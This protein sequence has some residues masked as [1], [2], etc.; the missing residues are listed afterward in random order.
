MRCLSA[1]SRFCTGAVIIGAA[2]PA[3]S[4][5]CAWL[6]ASRP[7]AAVL[8][9]AR[10]AIAP[11]GSGRCGP[12]RSLITGP[13][14]VS[15]TFRIWSGSP[16][17][18]MRSSRTVKG[19]GPSGVWY[20]SSGCRRLDEHVLHVGAGGG[21]GPGDVA[22][23][24]EHQEWH[25][26]CGGADQHARRA[27]RCAPGTRCRGSRTPDAGRRRAAA[28]RWRCGGR[29]PPIRSRRFPAACKGPGSAAG[30]ARESR[31][32][33]ACT[34]GCAGPASGRPSPLAGGH[35]SS[36]TCCGTWPASDWRDSSVRQ[37]SDSHR[38]HGLAPQQAVGRLP[39]F[40][41]AKDQE[42]RRAEAARS[43]I[44]A[45]TPRA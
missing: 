30:S 41:R 31:A 26:R 7:A 22:V 2:L 37:L 35:S 10:L 42:L 13:W 11:P 43:A 38:P 1:T 4:T 28:R 32:I 21:E 33:S 20:S 44:Q 9:G 27:S 6:S 23:M 39:W 29:P 5:S 8:P 3:S 14:R 19:R 25:A 18:L 40:G 12:V 36:I 17:T 15:R 24:A 16:R 34:C 45:F